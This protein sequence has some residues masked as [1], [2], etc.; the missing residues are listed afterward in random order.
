M[1]DQYKTTYLDDDT[2][3]PTVQRNWLE[4][5]PILVEYE[6]ERPFRRHVITSSVTVIGRQEEDVDL[7]LDERSVSR[8]H[9]RLECTGTDVYLTDLGSSNRTYLNGKRVDETQRV[10]HG[11]KIRIGKV[12][13]RYYAP[14]STDHALFEAAYSMAVQD[15]LLRIFRKE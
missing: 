2:H 6:E 10:F 9:C 12:K 1:S 7:W 15:G 8:Q 14:G 11:D 3:V 13:L 4:R 5:F